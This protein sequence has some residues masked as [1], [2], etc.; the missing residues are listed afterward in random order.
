MRRSFKT[1]KQLKNM[2]ISSTPQL[3][4]GLIGEGQ[5]MVIFGAGGTGK[6]NFSLHLA[7]NLTSGEDFLDFYKIERPY[8]V[9]YIQGEGEEAMQQDRWLRIG[10]VVKQN[11]ENFLNMH[12]SGLALDTQTGV[13]DLIEGLKGVNF[14]PEVIIID[15]L[16][17]MIYT[18]DISEHK[19]CNI[20]T[21]HIDE[22][23]AHFGCAVIVNHHEHRTKFT[24]FG[25]E[26]KEGVNKI[27]GSHVLRDWATTTFQL[28][29]EGDLDSD[30]EKFL[31][32]VN[33][34]DRNGNCIRIIHLRLVGDG[35]N[36]NSPLYF[37]KVD[38][39]A[40][41]KAYRKPVLEH[42]QT[43]KF[44]DISTISKNLGIDKHIV[45]SVLRQF[46]KEG[47]V[48]IDYEDYTWSLKESGK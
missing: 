11:D 7:A 24:P 9:L 38:E 48:K 6:S 8:R 25:K 45:G 40:S 34:K 33:D 46:V 4:K 30:T 26:I 47:K 1:G 17:K 22:I 5:V 21:Q 10:K 23:R 2:T 39:E 28:R 44:G 32:L 13:I 14:T 19:T 31:C 3:V 12:I 20:L 35:K 29:V 37:E 43:T 15:P 41:P 36:R 42:L 16:Y 18:G 27:S